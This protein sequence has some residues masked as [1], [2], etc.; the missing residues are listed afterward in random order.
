MSRLDEIRQRLGW[1]VDD[2]TT[3]HF[4]AA[5]VVFLLAELDRLR[6]SRNEHRS[7]ARRFETYA[8][9]EGRTSAALNDALSRL[10]PCPEGP[11]AH[12]GTAHCAH[13]GEVCCL[14][15]IGQ[16][17]LEVQAA[18][19]ACSDPQCKCIG[20]VDAEGGAA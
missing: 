17:D 7:R 14:C 9:M 1:A 12:G 11:Y 13:P 8:R 2:E 19:A 20:P 4:T 15:D 18:C 5:D 6:R 3:S 16:P 10:H